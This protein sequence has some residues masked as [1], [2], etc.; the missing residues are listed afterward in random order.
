TT[1]PITQGLAPGNLTVFNPAANMSV[2]LG[3]IAPSATILATRAGA[4]DAAILVADQGATLL[5]G[6]VTPAR[7]AFLFLEDAGYTSATAAA[8]QI[9]DR[10]ACWT[11]RFDPVIGTHPAPA[12]AAPGQSASFTV[13]AT[14][15]GPMGYQWRRHGA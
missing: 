4:A 3:S 8:I 12:V 9:L 13:A 6:Y 2:G 5:G 7:R 15:A 1:H 11:G 14:G 10:A